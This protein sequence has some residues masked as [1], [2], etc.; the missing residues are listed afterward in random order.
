MN[1][2]QIIKLNESQFNNLVT[3]I[4]TESVKKVLNETDPRTLAS[5]SEKRSEQAQGKRP[6]SPSQRRKGMTPQEI[7]NQ[8]KQGKFA[9]VRAFND[10]Y[11]KKSGS[12]NYTMDIGSGDDNYPYRATTYYDEGD[13]KYSHGQTINFSKNGDDVVSHRT[14]EK[15]INYAERTDNNIYHPYDYIGKDA[16]KVA[17]QMAMGDGRYIKGQGW[18]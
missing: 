10:Q 18:Q 11:G 3:K 8:A 17:K 12:N 1:K 9:A 16:T 13:P 4:V 14:G 7:E 2:R 6:L 5:Y 15:G